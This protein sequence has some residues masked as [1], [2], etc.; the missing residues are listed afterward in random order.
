METDKVRER[1]ARQPEGRAPLTSRKKQRLA[2]STPNFR[3]VDNEAE[4]PQD[5]RRTV[6]RADT[7]AAA[8]QQHIAVKGFQRVNGF[9]N[10]FRNVAL[11]D[12]R[13]PCL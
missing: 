5:L 3:A 4:S 10:V 7:R 9:I 11:K 12:C 1:I 6:V 8:D 13:W 2:G